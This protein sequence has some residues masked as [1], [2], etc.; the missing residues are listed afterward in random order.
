MSGE[1]AGVGFRDGSVRHSWRSVVEVLAAFAALGLSSFGGPMAHLGYFRR[2]FVARRGWLAEREYAELVALC[3]FL[4]GPS[5]SQV[6]MALGLQRAG[7]LGGL[8]AWL[9]FTMPSA[10]LLLLFAW[11][12]TGGGWAGSAALH[13]CKVAA[14]AVVAQA[15]WG[16]GKSFCHGVGGLAVA[17]LAAVIVAGLD[18]VA[19]QLGALAVGAV[20]GRW[21]VGPTE[22]PAADTAVCRVRRR[23]GA[24]LLI[25]WAA[26]LLLTTIV[27]VIAPHP[28]ID[29]LATLYRAGSLVFGGGHVVLPLLQTGVVASGAV[30]QATFMAGYGAAQAVPGPLFS[31]AAYLGA[32]TPSGGFGVGLLALLALFLP[33][34]LLV[35]GA[36]PFWQ[37]LRRQ[38]GVRQALSGVNAAVVGVLLAALYDPVWPS[39]IHTWSDFV[40]AAVVYGLLVWGRVSAAWLVPLC[41]AGAAIVAA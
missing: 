7:W 13:G 17:M 23:T 41:A 9:G 32:V 5:S 24:L 31:F 19:G 15:A 18:G 16:M 28:R 30:D 8:A 10:I 34:F 12:V 26:L 38:R 21:M 2:E 40:M 1:S 11:G 4:P 36:L 20:L 6:G 33:G 3:Q 39:A 22:P 29:L 35:A 14:V 27:D 37:A 25:G